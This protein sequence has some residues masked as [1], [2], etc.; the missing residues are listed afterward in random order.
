MNHV[1]F[2][3]LLKDSSLF[4]TFVVDQ[5]IPFGSLGKPFRIQRKQLKEFKHHLILSLYL[6]SK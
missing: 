2:V 4:E 5:T 6:V 1:F 3:F